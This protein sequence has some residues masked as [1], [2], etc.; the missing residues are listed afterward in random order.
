MKALYRHFLIKQNN[1]LIVVEL[2]LDGMDYTLK[3]LNGGD[4]AIEALE[5]A[6]AETGDNPNRWVVP[7]YKNLFPELHQL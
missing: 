6:I 5:K 2:N 3:A 4:E 7:F 1:D